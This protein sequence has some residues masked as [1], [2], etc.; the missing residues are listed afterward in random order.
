MARAEWPFLY[1]VTVFCTEG[2]VF[3]QVN[4]RVIGLN[5]RSLS[6]DMRFFFFLLSHRGFKPLEEG[7]WGG[8]KFASIVINGDGGPLYSKKEAYI[9]GGGGVGEF[10]L[11][12]FVC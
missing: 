2:A 1:V 6:A 5:W 7:E 10:N 4:F 12:K 11:P 3:N 9:S 8:H